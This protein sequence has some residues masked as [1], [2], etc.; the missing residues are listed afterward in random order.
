MADQMIKLN[1]GA[2]ERS[3]KSVM[4]DMTDD[5]RQIRNKTPIT[6]GK[7]ILSLSQ[8]LVPI[9]TG[10]LKKSGRLETIKGEGVSIIY[11]AT[12]EEEQ[13]AQLASKA[14]GGLG[15]TTIYRFSITKPNQSYAEFVDRRTKFFSSAIDLFNKG[16]PIKFKLKNGDDFEYQLELDYSKRGGYF[17]SSDIIREKRAAKARRTIKE[18]IEATKPYYSYTKE[19]E[20]EHLR[21][22]SRLKKKYKRIYGRDYKE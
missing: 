7:K 20:K 8:A 5:I 15:R 4:K 9:Y 10:V 6:V 19:T 17:L 14:E 16:E 12:V 3:I 18:N 13:K 1:K 2:L 22:I 11:D 21:Y